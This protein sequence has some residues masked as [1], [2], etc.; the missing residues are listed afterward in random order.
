MLA[1][2]ARNR[3][4]RSAS[5]CQQSKGRRIEVRFPDSTAILICLRG[6]DDAGLERHPEQ[7]SSGAGPH[8]DKD[9]YDL[10]LEERRQIPKS[11]STS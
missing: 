6:D 8:W 3:S 2:S 1:Y 7:D 4:A 5:P 11:V 9:L 10:R